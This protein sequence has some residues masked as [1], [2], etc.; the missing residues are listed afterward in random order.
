MLISSIIGSS[1]LLLYSCHKDDDK[2]TNV[3]VT[4]LEE[5]HCDETSSIYM[6]TEYPSIEESETTATSE[7]KAAL[8]KNKKWK[9]GQTIKV[10]FLNGSQFLQDNVK[11]YAETWLQ[12]AN[13]SFEY[14][15]PNDIAD[16]KV[17]FKW[18]CD[19]GSWSY[20]GTDCKKI[21]Q[22]K[23]T[24]NFGW[25]DEY[26]S[27]VEFQRV[28][29]HEFGHA[30]GLIH[31]HQHPE[32]DIQWNK[33]VVYA[34]YE[35]FSGWTKKEVDHNIFEKYSSSQTNYSNFDSQS[36]MLYAIS[37]ELTLN[38]FSADWNYKLSETDKNFIAKMYP[39]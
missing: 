8:V 5:A 27:S 22:Y 20:I 19:Y 3:N 4:Q 30:L 25:F 6:C 24:I 7:L 13:L 31:E 10:K 9:T 29:L 35:T 23:P 12:Y 36:I 18:D 39:Y 38:G 14:M 16:I 21:A 32:S 2:M 26:T 1:L 37:S 33:S 28:V 34:Y 11:K 15:E 17:A